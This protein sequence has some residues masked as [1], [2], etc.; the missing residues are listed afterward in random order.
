MPLETL[1]FPHVL[2]AF[3]QLIL[4]TVSFPAFC[5]Y[6][7]GSF[8]IS[9]ITANHRSSPI[10]AY[11]CRVTYH[12]CSSLLPYHHILWY[13]ACFC[14]PPPVMCFAV[15]LLYLSC[16][17]AFVHQTLVLFCSNF[18]SSIMYTVGTSFCIF[19]LLFFLTSIVARTTG[20]SMAEVY[21]IE[22]IEMGKNSTLTFIHT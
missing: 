15:I 16:V 12:S 5:G 7:S 22:N 8:E 11:N 13:S 17:M 21:N 6:T 20:C 4:H 1:N 14:A 19:L 2:P 3:C 9:K 10:L 18:V